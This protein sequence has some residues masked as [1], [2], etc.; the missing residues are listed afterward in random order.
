MRELLLRLLTGPRKFAGRYLL[1]REPELL[2]RSD[3]ADW[4]G[5]I[6]RR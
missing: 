1:P 5:L 4:C 3:S 2:P 6:R